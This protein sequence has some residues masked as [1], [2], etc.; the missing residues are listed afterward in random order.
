MRGAIHA[1]KYGGLRPMAHR[2]GAMLAEAIGK[3]E[4]E[5]PFE[6]L[7]VPVPLHRAKRRQRGFN[8]ARLLA[9]GAVAALRKQDPRWRLRLAS[10]TLLR[11]RAT[12]TQ[13]GLTPHQRRQNLRGAFA[14]ADPDAVRAKKILLIDDILTTGAT[15]S[16]AALA[17]RRAGAE[18]VWVVTLARAHRLSD[19]FDEGLQK[20]DLTDSG[21]QVIR[22]TQ[23]DQVVRR[24][25]LQDHPS[26]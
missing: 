18:A 13:A 4:G 12:E 21:P 11:Q 23:P 24:D 14:V 9:A 19:R 2:L 6:M 17:L 22:W 25:S 7:V 26:F 3:L 10:R 20:E 1:L 16:A 8:Q 5:A 15:A